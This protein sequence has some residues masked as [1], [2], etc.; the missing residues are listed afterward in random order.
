MKMTTG[1]QASMVDPT[2]CVAA[3]A[4]ML[5]MVSTQNQML[6]NDKERLLL[7]QRLNLASAILHTMS[8]FYIFQQA[9]HFFKTV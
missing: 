7:K 8:I 3:T 2:M 4:A 9:L 1:G 6:I 5:V